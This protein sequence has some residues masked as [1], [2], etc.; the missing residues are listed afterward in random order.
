MFLR[1]SIF[2]T[3]FLMLASIEG[4][5]AARIPLNEIKND[6]GVRLNL[7]FKIVGI[8]KY[9]KTLQTEETWKF[10]HKWAQ[11]QLEVVPGTSYEV[12]GHPWQGGKKSAALINLAEI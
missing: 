4:G 5:Q 9:H 3:S 6:T 11:N 10:T 7:D 12:C 1:L 2:I 8:S